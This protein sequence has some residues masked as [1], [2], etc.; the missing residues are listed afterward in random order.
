MTLSLEWDPR[1][2]AMGIKVVRAQPAA[3]ETCYRLVKA[4]WLSDAESV[5]RHHIYV[6]V[7]DE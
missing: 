5:G 1:L 3:G 6:E 4:R 2:D 7:L